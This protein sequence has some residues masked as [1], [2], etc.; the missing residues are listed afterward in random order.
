MKCPQ[1]G[2]QNLIVES[3]GDGKRREACR[4]CG[5]AE[6]KDGQDRR[7]LTEVPPADKRRVLTEAV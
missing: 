4:E 6:V 5:Y 2:A 3:L 7:L 1:C